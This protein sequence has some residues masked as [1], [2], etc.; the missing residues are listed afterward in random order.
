MSSTTN[1]TLADTLRDAGLYDSLDPND[2]QPSYPLQ[3]NGTDLVMPSSNTAGPGSYYNQYDPVNQIY[4]N[5]VYDTSGQNYSPNHIPTPQNN[6][7][8]DTTHSPASSVAPPAFIQ[9]NT[10]PFIDHQS[11]QPPNNPE[12][13]FTDHNDDQF[14]QP[15]M[16]TQRDKPRQRQNDNKQ[17]KLVIHKIFIQI[18]LLPF[19]LYNVRMLKNM[20]HVLEEKEQLGQV[21]HQIVILLNN[22]LIIPN[23]P[24]VLCIN[25]HLNQNQIILKKIL[26]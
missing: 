25:S 4:P 26:I 5:P 14:Q 21:S 7:A 8:F 18:N 11:L 19:K 10:N 23:H 13:F 15:P 2:Q 16:A 1:R 24:D 17:G 3:M 12:M 9:Q 20:N 6:P 22:H